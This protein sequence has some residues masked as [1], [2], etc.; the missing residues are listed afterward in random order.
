MKKPTLTIA[1][2]TPFE[3]DAFLESVDAL[4]RNCIYQ[5]E[6]CICEFM[7]MRLS[8]F[9]IYEGHFLYGSDVDELRVE[10][11]QVCEAF[12]ERWSDRQTAKVEAQQ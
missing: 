2:E 8:E 1:V 3:M 11:K 12:Y 4:M 9:N 7:L 5:N 6:K 10:L